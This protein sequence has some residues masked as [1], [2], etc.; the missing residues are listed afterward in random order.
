M[1][2]AIICLILF[3]VESIQVSFSQRVSILKNNDSPQAKYA[4]GLLQK[5]LVKQGYTVK[6]KA[7][8]YTINLGVKSGSLGKEAYSVVSNQKNLTIT[9][10]D[11]TGLIYGALTVAE[12]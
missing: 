2:K 7:G 8:E 9:G 4:A 5:A 11:G 12:S 6:D 10:G 3:L 1:K